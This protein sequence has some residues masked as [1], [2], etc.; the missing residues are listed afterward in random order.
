MSGEARD[1]QR[2]IK[3]RVG[4]CV[5]KHRVGAYLELG[6]DFLDSVEN[7]P[8]KKEPTPKP[9]Q[10]PSS[11]LIVSRSLSGCTL[12]HDLNDLLAWD[13]AIPQDALPSTTT[14]ADIMT[15]S[16]LLFYFARSSVYVVGLGFIC[17]S[18]Q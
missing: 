10:I 11:S 5:V 13:V 9:M 6:E 17:R 16:A 12:L 8:S 2:T 15:I 1:S 18:G 14:A 4:T 7:L 3:V